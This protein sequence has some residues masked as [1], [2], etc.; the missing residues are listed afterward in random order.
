[1]KQAAMCTENML[2]FSRISWALQSSPVLTISI[3]FA[4]IADKAQANYCLPIYLRTRRGPLHDIS[5]ITRENLQP[6]FHIRYV[7]VFLRLM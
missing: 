3:L 1:M 7:L 2:A 6:I 4:V 5:V